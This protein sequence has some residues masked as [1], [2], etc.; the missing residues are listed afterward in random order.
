MMTALGIRSKTIQ[1]NVQLLLNFYF[2]RGNVRLVTFV[3]KGEEKSQDCGT[4]PKYRGMKYF[5]F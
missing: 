2:F 1:R 5:A 3:G 4:K